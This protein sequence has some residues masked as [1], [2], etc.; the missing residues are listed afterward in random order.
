MGQD[1]E[2]CA[3]AQAQE[4]HER[5]QPGKRE[6][7]TVD[8]QADHR[9]E[10]TA[11]HQQ[12]GHVPPFREVERLRCGCGFV[13]HSYLRLARSS[14]GTSSIAPNWQSCRARRYATI[15]QRSSMVMLAP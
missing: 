13:V 1:Q 14:W 9:K 7:L 10:A 4:E 12:P 8:Q 5:Q 6:L 2:Q 11:G 3:Q 15:A